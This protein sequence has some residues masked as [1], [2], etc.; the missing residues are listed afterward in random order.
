DIA[1]ILPLTPLQQGL[2]YHTKTT[3]GNDDSYAVQL[4]ISFS[5]ALDARR[6]REAMTVVVRRHPNLAARFHIQF[7]TPVQAIPS[8]PAPG[9][10]Y[11]DLQAGNIDEQIQRVCLE[12]R[13]AVCKLDE[14]P[15]FRATLIRTASDQHRFVLT[16][17]HIVMDGWS[18]PILLGEIFASYHGNRLPPPT[19]YRAFTAWLAGRDLDAAEN[20]WREVLADLE[21]PTLVGRS[22]RLALGRQGVESFRLSEE[23]TRAIGELARSHRTTVNIVLQSAWAQLLMWLTGRHDVAFGVVVSGRP[24]DVSGAE[25]MVGLLINTVPV[26][27]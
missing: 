18:L 6:L 13:A 25:S 27:A 15:V 10:R 5:G 23:T 19:P 11:V 20:A 26:R 9:W 24:A 3:Q 1:D 2:L 12:E 7:D 4:A 17:H 22:G 8:A 14:A 16:F 21:S